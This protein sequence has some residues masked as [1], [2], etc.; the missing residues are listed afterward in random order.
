MYAPEVSND[1]EFDAIAAA[2]ELG[3]LPDDEA[4][5]D[6]AA[7][8]REIQGLTAELE[9]AQ[10]R[11]AKAEA[12]LQ[13]QVDRARQRIERDAAIALEQRTHKL[14]R[15][16]IDVLDDLDRALGAARQHGDR[17]SVLEGVELVR[18]AFLR[19]LA[20]HGVTPCPAEGRFDPNL[21]EAVAAVPVASP[22]QDGMIV[23]VVSAGYL[24]GDRVLRPA[25]VAVGKRQ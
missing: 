8:Q 21:H 17:L 24:I 15:S 19:K 7:L 4:T 23:G 20:E 1:A 18:G 11:A 9:A 5:G 12:E 10:R 16:F 14:L 13:H 25:R 2:A 3:D 22:D 6:V